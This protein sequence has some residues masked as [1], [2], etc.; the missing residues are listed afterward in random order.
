[1]YES[2]AQ[3]RLKLFAHQPGGDLVQEHHL[4][5]AHQR[6]NG[7]HALALAAAH[8]ADHAAAHPGA[9]AVTEA[10]EL[11]HQVWP[12]LAIEQLAREL[13]NCGVGELTERHV[14]AQLLDR[15]AFQARGVARR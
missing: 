5:A 14:G 2:R 13:C 1:M 12:P 9:L 10:K 7:G 8:A 11:E 4:L 3:I 15:D 6:L